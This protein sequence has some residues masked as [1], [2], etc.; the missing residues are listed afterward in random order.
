MKHFFKI[1]TAA[2]AAMLLTVGC[3]KKE[4]PAGEPL[5]DVTANNI[6]GTWKLTEWSGGEMAGGSYVYI[7][8]TRR[9]QTFTIYENLDSFSARRITGRY[10]ILT[11]EELGAVIWGQYDY[12]NNDWAHRYIVRGLT[13]TKMT[14]IAKDDP[15]D[16]SVYERC[17]AVPDDI[18]AELP[19]EE[20]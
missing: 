11:D 16:V 14:W 4:G 19:A 17:D 6:S 5:L 13:A 15:E 18:L 20:E 9:D 3:D 7:E 2:V 10:N 12:T 1:A 8:F